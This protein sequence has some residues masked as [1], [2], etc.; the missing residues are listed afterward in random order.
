[1]QA[2]ID[3][4]IPLLCYSGGRMRHLNL[5]CNLF[6]K[7]IRERCTPYNNRALHTRSKMRSYRVR[8]LFS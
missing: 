4:P 6:P 7:R 1:M 3:S 5:L 8:T 2:W